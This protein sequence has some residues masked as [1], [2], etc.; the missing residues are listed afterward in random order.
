MQPFQCIAIWCYKIICRQSNCFQYKGC[1]LQQQHS[2][3]WWQIGLKMN[4]SIARIHISRERNYTQ[5]Q[6]SIIN[7]KSTLSR[8]GSPGEMVDHWS[9]YSHQW[10][11]GV[12][13]ECT[14]WDDEELRPPIQERRGRKCSG[15]RVG[16]WR[17]RKWR[18]LD[19]AGIAKEIWYGR[20]RGWQ[21]H[22][23]SSRVAGCGRETRVPNM[24]A[25]KIAAGRT[26]YIWTN[27]KGAHCHPFPLCITSPHSAIAV[28]CSYCSCTSP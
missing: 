7:H 26:G 11:Q 28:V 13:K 27:H 14:S 15:W 24:N 18:V 20:R 4:T 23:Q 10:C 17:W 1:N 8:R 12:V 2:S 16:V 19:A 5:T 22:L 9:G 25:R 3:E 6:Q 21:V